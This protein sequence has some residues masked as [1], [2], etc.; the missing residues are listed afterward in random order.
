[1]K[2]L[3]IDIKLI[4][5]CSFAGKE[6]KYAY[7]HSTFKNKTYIMIGTE[8]KLPPITVWFAGFVDKL[9]AYWYIPVLVL[10]FIVGAI[11]AYINTPKGKY[12]LLFSTFDK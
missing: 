1:M 5:Y 12:N 6:G 11:I 3:N 2:H 10:L 4:E 8:E 9:V 7:N